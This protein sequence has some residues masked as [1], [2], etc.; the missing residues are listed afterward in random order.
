MAGQASAQPKKQGGGILSTI[1][2]VL[3][4]GPFVGQAREN[5]EYRSQRH[6]QD[7]LDSQ[8]QQELRQ[9]QIEQIRN[10]KPSAPHYWETNDGSLGVIGADGQPQILYKDPTP[11][12]TWAQVDLPNGQKQLIPSMNGMPQIGGI[13]QMP[14]QSG[15]PAEGFDTLPQGFSVRQ[16]GAAPAAPRTFPL[17]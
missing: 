15:G 6:Q 1:L 2:D 7:L 4:Y 17:R 9:A 12:V 16:G 8:A 11:K 3:R 5:R 10:P 14:G 13:P